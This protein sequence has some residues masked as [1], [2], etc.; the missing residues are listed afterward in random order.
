ML[1]WPIIPLLVIRN[2]IH[3]NWSDWFSWV[4]IWASSW[5]TL[6]WGVEI[7]S[8]ER[9]CAAWAS[10]KSPM[11][12]WMSLMALIQTTKNN[13]DKMN[14]NVSVTPYVQRIREN[15]VVEQG[16]QSDSCMVLELTQRSSCFWHTYSCLS[17]PY[18]PKNP[19]LLHKCPGALYEN[20]LPCH[21]QKPTSLINTSL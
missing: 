2:M 7:G 1:D 17:N 14:D 20:I 3:I 19:V 4:F 18:S 8:E 16:N 10:P 13:R 11:F 6:M 12:C 15:R 9:L 21:K 5:G